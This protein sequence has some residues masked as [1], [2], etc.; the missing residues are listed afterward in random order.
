MP[1]NFEE[2]ITKIITSVAPEEQQ[3]RDSTIHIA[4]T[5]LEDMDRR[6]GPESEEYLPYHNAQHCVD[7]CRRTVRLLNIV[8]PYVRPKYREDIYDIGIIGGAVHDYEQGLGQ[9][10]NERASAKRGIDIVDKADRKFNDRSLQ[11][12]LG[13][14]IL[15]TSVLYSEDGEIIQPLIQRGSHDPLKFAVGFADING[16][17]M[18]GDRR[19]FIDAIKLC[20]ERIENPSIDD[21]YEFLVNQAEFL[22]GRLNDGRVKSDIAYYFPENIEDVY[23]DMRK[24]FH[25]NI[26]SSYRLALLIKSRP[27][28]KKVLGFFVQNVDSI[29]RSILGNFISDA[30]RRKIAQQSTMLTDL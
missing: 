29:D 14:G 8:Y 7:V 11:K 15:A 20:Y 1:V 12:R 27:E 6:Y 4:V 30:V 17:A 24:A 13:D 10:E 16:T 21:L 28:L 23:A 5:A 22:K 18:E 26:L 25:G 3:V 9:L 2:E 19:M